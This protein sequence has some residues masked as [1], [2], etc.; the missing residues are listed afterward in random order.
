MKVGQAARVAATEVGQVRTLVAVVIAARPQ[1]VEEHKARAM[2]RP[3]RG[4]KV[5]A[6]S[7]LSA[8]VQAHQVHQRAAARKVGA[9]HQAATVE[10][11]AARRLAALAAATVQDAADLLRD[12]R[13]ASPREGHVGS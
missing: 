4:E 12:Q 1:P 13:G 8:A 11:R 6:A 2:R 9:A 7:P 10:A 3:V 5:R